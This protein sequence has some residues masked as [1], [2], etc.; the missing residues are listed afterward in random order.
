M[1]SC[2]VLIQPQ[3]KTPAPT[4]EVQAHIYD[5]QCSMRIRVPCFCCA[6]MQVWLHPSSVVSD[7]T[8]A[9]LHHRHVIYL[10]KSK[11]TRV[12]DTHTVEVLRVRM[13]VLSVRV[14]VLRVRVLKSRLEL[15]CTM[16]QHALQLHPKGS[17]HGSMVVT[18]TLSASAA[19]PCVQHM[20]TIQTIA[21]FPQYCNAPPC[22]LCHIVHWCFPS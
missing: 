16:E 2:V 19:D 14:R 20:P 21:A 3:Q 7:L 17:M 5:R 15:P 12:G 6:N 8:A 11:T 1:V 18:L 13:R 9:Q 4:L 10:E 22:V